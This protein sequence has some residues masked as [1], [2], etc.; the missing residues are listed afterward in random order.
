MNPY[1]VLNIK[2][3][4][5]PEEIRKAHREKIKQ[6]HPDSNPGDTTA[7]EKFREV[8]E[9]YEA[10]TKP[11]PRQPQFQSDWFGNDPFSMFSDFFRSSSKRKEYSTECTISFI[12]AAKGKEITLTL[13]LDKLCPSCD[14]EMGDTEACKQC[15]GS[16]GVIFKHGNMSVRQACSACRGQGKFLKNACKKCHGNGTIK[17]STPLNI[18]IPAGVRQNNLLNLNNSN[19]TI[20]VKINVDPHRLF[21]RDNNDLVIVIPVSYTE[22][23]FGITI[24]IPTLDGNYNITIPAN[25][26]SGDHV[27]IPGKGFNTPNS[28]AIGDLV[29]II[30][31]D[32]AGTE[33]KEVKEVLNKLSELEKKYPGRKKKG[34]LEDIKNT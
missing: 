3:D 8:Q 10:L 5:S 32:P 31:I 28:M 1:K 14:G 7:A 11:K 19:E 23:V 17:E 27:R 18:K 33:E 24:E 22:A 25:S 30:E 29:A 34:F 26:V 13:E 20:I 21:Q 6:L 9:A 16:G 15:N 2:E 4:A 12:E